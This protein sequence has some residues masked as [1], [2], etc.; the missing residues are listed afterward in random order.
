MIR[1]DRDPLEDERAAARLTTEPVR[2]PIDEGR[3]S[4]TLGI[5]LVL[6]ALM[7][8][9]PWAGGGATP[10]LPISLTTAEPVPVTPVPT[11]D[12]TAEGLAAPICLG[13]GAWRVASLE[14]WQTQDV[15][16]WRAI[17]PIGS[18]TGPLDTAIPSVPIVAIQLTAL[19]WCA[20][21]FGPDLPVGPATVT[22]WTVQG[23]EATPLQL[24]QVRPPDGVTPIAAL[25]VPL[26]LCPEPTICAPPLPSP[27]PR[28]WA[29]ERV[30]FQYRDAGS[31][32]VEWFAADVQILP[33]PPGA[34][35]TAGP[36]PAGTL[37][38]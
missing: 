22:A 20:P 35:A 13:T 3:L 33:A 1:R 29:T 2:P 19:G 16:V 21:A 25:Y 17:E 12:R 7:I 6:V 27:A 31:A 9:K 11:E 38:R 26:T 4:T 14:Q 30:V 28:P 10:A 36:S 37:P 23:A 18:A 15:R 5:V 32:R 24:Q 8:L 34:T